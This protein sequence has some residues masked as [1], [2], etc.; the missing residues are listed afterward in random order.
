MTSKLDVTIQSESAHSAR[1]CFYVCGCV[2]LGAWVFG[3]TKT[4]YK[5]CRGALKGLYNV[6]AASLQCLCS[7]FAVS[8]QSLGSA[9]AVSLEHA[10]TGNEKDHENHQKSYL[11]ELIVQA[12][13]FEGLTGCVQ[14]GYQNI[15]KNGP[16]WGEILAKGCPKLSKWNQTHQKCAKI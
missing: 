4:Q 8:V 3:P 12:M 14:K 16:T 2:G 5:S 10:K 15:F 9:F 6:F 11:F 1:P 7:V 13:V